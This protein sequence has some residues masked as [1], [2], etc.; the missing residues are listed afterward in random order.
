MRRQNQSDSSATRIR[1]VR[2][3]VPR[4]QSVHPDPIENAASPRYVWGTLIAAWMLCLLPWRDWQA[5]PDVLLLVLAFW[6]VHDSRRVGMVVCFVFGL[7]MDVHDVGPLGLQ[8][9]SFSL[10]GYGANVLHRRLLRFDLWSQGLHMLPVF[11][12]AKLV[13]VL[14]NAWLA[15]YWAGWMWTVGVVLTAA[16]WPVVGW[17]L[18]LPQHRMSDADASSV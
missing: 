4:P 2:P 7:L 1:S 3:P 10:V 16:L 8:A 12:V 11:F 13:N 18:L 15:N 6:S 9:L 17:L 14:I 5:A